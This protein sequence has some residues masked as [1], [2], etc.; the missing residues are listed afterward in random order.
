MIQPHL[1]FLSPDRCERIHLAALEILR[2]TGVRVFHDESLRLLAEAD[3]PIQEENRVFIPPA[4]VDGRWSSR[5]CGGWRATLETESYP[6]PVLG[7]D[8]TPAAQPDGSGKASGNGG[9]RHSDRA[10]PG[11]DSTAEEVNYILG[12]SDK[13]V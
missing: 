5:R 12:L 13:E 9:K 4:L 3:C 2:R 10:F 7:T 6:A 1:L 8:H 11:S